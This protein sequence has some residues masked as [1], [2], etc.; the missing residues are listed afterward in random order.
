[1]PGASGHATGD[2]Q[3]LE[4]VNMIVCCVFVSCMLYSIVFY[5]I[6]TP[7]MYQHSAISSFALGLASHCVENVKA[8]PNKFS[9]SRPGHWHIRM[10]AGG[11]FPFFIIRLASL[12]NHYL[13]EKAA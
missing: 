6:S 4:Y 10:R 5:A 1:M 12:S 11:P 2:E 9:V 3:D 8:T 7:L 13:S